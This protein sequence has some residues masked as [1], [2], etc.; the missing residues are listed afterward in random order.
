MCGRRARA[1]A[2]L[3]GTKEGIV[4]SGRPYHID[5]E[6]NH[7]IPGVITALGWAVLSEDSILGADD[8][9]TLRVL[10]QWTYHAR[11]Y[12]AAEIIGNSDDLELVQLNSFGCGLDA[13]VTDQVNEI[14]ARHDKIYTVLKID[15]VNNLGAVKIRLR[16]LTQALAKRERMVHRVHEGFSKVEFTKEMGKDYTL[17]VPQMAPDHFEILKES[18]FRRPARRVL[19]EINR[20]VENEGLTYVN[21]DACYPSLPW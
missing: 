12:R 18:G 3:R 4:L 15:E 8:V 11:L 13:V 9:G 10:D 7:G 16:S 19:T 2:W 6:I 17:L 14:L 1:L 5:P 21:N 20:E